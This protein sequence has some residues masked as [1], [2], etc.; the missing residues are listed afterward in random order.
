[1][2]GKTEN[3]ESPAMDTVLYRKVPTP[4]A[5]YNYVNAL[6]ILPRGDSYDIGKVIGRKIDADGNVVG[7]SNDNLI[8]DTMEY[9]FEFDDGEVRKLTE[10]LI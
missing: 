9:S 6:V 3:D 1:M 2:A 8:L 7:R 4:E 5:N 10:I